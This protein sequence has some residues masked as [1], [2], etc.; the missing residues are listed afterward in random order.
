MLP[1]SLLGIVIL[2][3][4]I[5]IGFKLIKSVVKIGF[6]VLLV[7]IAGYLIFGGMPEVG[8]LG[9]G[10]AGVALPQFENSSVKDV[11]VAVKNVAWGVEV[12]SADFDSDGT[13]VLA[14]ANTGQLQ[15]SGVEIYV[16]GELVGVTNSPPEVLEKGDVGIFDTDYQATG[17][18]VIIVKAGKAK[19]EAAVN[20]G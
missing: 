10:E 5:F 7:I 4:A 17:P 8:G 16:N 19:T 18:A 1:Q 20:L 11:I 14:I 9:D 2:I 3:A 12:L 6:V 15:L 13:L